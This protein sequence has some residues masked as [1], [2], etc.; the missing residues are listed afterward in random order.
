[1]SAV[2]TYEGYTLETDGMV[3]Q[4]RIG[5]EVRKFDTAGQWK[6]YIDYINGK[7]IKRNRR[8]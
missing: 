2:L 6:Q 1:M 7:G 8:D 5:K 3:Y 4:C